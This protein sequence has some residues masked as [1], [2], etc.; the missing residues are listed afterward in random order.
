MALVNPAQILFDLSQ[1]APGNPVPEGDRERQEGGD[2]NGRFMVITLELRSIHPLPG[3]V[4]H[5]LVF[6]PQHLR[7]VS[8]MLYKFGL[9]FQKTRH[10]FKPDFISQK[11]GLKIGAV[12][13][14]GAF[15][16]IEIGQNV[17]PFQIHEGPDEETIS[18]RGN[19]GQT[20]RPAPPQEPHEDRFCLIIQAM[21]QGDLLGMKSDPEILKKGIP[22]IPRPFFQRSCPFPGG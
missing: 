16:G 2:G 14:I 1:D 6:F 17:L 10:P 4:I 13:Y 18:H 5:V 9:H 15:S 20:G 19:S 3:L 22:C 8:K 21:P 7:K 11:F 12:S